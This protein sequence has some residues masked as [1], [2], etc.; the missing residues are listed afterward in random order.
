MNCFFFV[1]GIL[2]QLA[3]LDPRSRSIPSFYWFF[4]FLLILRKIAKKNIKEGLLPR[5]K[6]SVLWFR[7][8]FVKSIYYLFTTHRFFCFAECWPAR[9]SWCASLPLLFFSPYPRKKNNPP[10]KKWDVNIKSTGCRPLLTKIFFSRISF[11]F[12]VFRSRRKSEQ[13]F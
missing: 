4:T 12:S 6:K 11:L 10:K 9:V 7:Q 3:W 8:L 2:H 5:T 13:R 1:A